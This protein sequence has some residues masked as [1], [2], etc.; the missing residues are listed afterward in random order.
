VARL[1]GRAGE[2]AQALFD[3]LGS[4]DRRL[5]VLALQEG[6]PEVPHRAHRFPS[7]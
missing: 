4:R 2:T 7:G 6:E 1:V 5:S 3:R